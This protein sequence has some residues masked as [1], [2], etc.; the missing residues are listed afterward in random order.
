M[1]LKVRNLERVGPLILLC[2]LCHSAWAQLSV[3]S[4]VQANGTVNVRQTPA[5]TPPLGTQSA[6]ALGSI[7]EGPESAFLNGTSYTWWKVNFDSGIDGWVASIGL[8]LV[9]SGTVD[10]QPLDVTRNPNSVAPGA[11]L[12]VSWKIRNNGTATAP[13]SR[14][15]VRIT[16]S[17]SSWGNG[18]NNVGS[19]LATST[20]SAGATIDQSTT[21]TAPSTPGTYYLWVVADNF[22]DLNQS[23]VNND[24]A[25]SSAF[26]VITPEQYAD[27]VP[28]N[29]GVSPSSGLA[30]TGVQVSFSVR[31]NGPGTSLATT[32]NIRLSTSSAA[33]SAGDPLLGTLNI[34]ALSSGAQQSLSLTYTIPAGTTA[35]QRHIWVIVEP[36]GAPN[37]NQGPNIGNDRVS[38]AFTVTSVQPTLSVTPAN[39]PT[40]PATAGTVSLSVNNTGDGTMSYSASV[41]PASSWLRINSGASGGNSGTIVVAYDANSGASRSSTIQVTANGASGSPALITLTQSG[42]TLPPGGLGF[43]YPIGNRGYAGGVAVPIPEFPTGIVQSSGGG[44]EIVNALFAGSGVANPV[45]QNNGSSASWWISQDVGTFN[46]GYG[47]HAA[48]DWNRGS[49]I[50]DVGE[51]VYAVAAGTVVE[52]RGGTAQSFWTIVL[53][54]DLG[55]GYTAYSIYGHVCPAS[56]SGSANINGTLGLKADFG[57]SVGGQV[58]RGDSIARIGALSTGP[59][60]HFEIRVNT[61]DPSPKPYF[62]AAGETQ[63]SGQ[64]SMTAEEV[65]SAYE[66]MRAAGFVDPSDFIDAHRPGPQEPQSYSISLIASPSAG[67]TVGGGGTYPAGSSRTVT[68]TASSGYTFANWTEGGSVVSQLTSYPF[69]L[70]SNRALVA[71][72]TASPPQ[73]ADLVPQNLGVSPSNGLAGTGVQVSFSVRNNGPGTSLATTANIRLSTSSAAPSAGDPLLGTVNIGGLSSGAQQSLSPSYTIP[74]GTTAGQRHIWVIV[75]PTG[76]PNANQGPNI[77]NDRVSVA[78]IVTSLQPTTYSIAPN[79]AAVDEGAGTLVFTIIRGGDSL[80]AETI[81]ASTVNGAANGYAANNGDYA[82]DVSNLPLNF[83]VGESIRT[84]AVSILND[85]I[86]ESAETFGFIVQRNASD[87]VATHL[88]KSTFTINDNDSPGNETDYP[89]A[90]WIAAGPGHFT[91]ATRAMGDVT[92]IVIH[93]T[94]DASYGAAITWFQDP[95][96]DTSAHYVVRRDGSVVQMVREKDIAHHAGTPGIAA[97][98]VWNERSIGIEVE[99]LANAT[100][101][102]DS[103][104]YQAVKHLVNSI[105]TRYDIPL[106]FPLATPVGSPTKLVAGIV[107]HGKAVQNGVDPVKWEWIYFQSLFEV[108]ADEIS[109]LLTINSPATG[110][111]VAVSSVVVSGTA[112]DSGRGDSGVTSVT[113]N[114]IRAGGD[115]AAGAE[116]ANWSRTVGLITGANTITVVAT[117]GA[118]N[119]TSS[120]RSVAYD[121]IVNPPTRVIALSGNL[122]F[123]EVA[124]GS[125]AQR[126]LTINNAGDSPLTVTGISYPTGF[127]GNWSGTVAAGNAQSI[128]IM[129]APTAAS[130]YGGDL[131]VHA[132]Q[133]SGTPTRVVTGVGT[134]GPILSGSVVAWGRNEQGQTTGIPSAE[135]PY[136]AIGNPPV[137]NGVA[138][139]GVKGIAVGE[140][141][142]VALKNDGTVVAWGVNDYG[143]LDIPADLN[144]VTAISTDGV[145]TIALKHDGTVVGWGRNDYGQSTAPVGLIG[146]KAIAAGVTHTLALKQDGTVVAWGN[147]AAG[148]INVPPGLSGVEAIAAG[149]YHSVA[150]KRD[151]RVIAWG[152]NDYGQASVPSDLIGIKAI[153]AGESHT[154]ALK[155]D[156]TV[157]SWG[158]NDQGQRDIPSGLGGVTAISAGARNTVVLKDDGTVAAWGA[159][160]TATGPELEFGQSIV[161]SGLNRVR[162]IAAGAF[163]AAALIADQ[164]D[165][166]LTQVAMSNGVFRYTLNGITGSKLVIEK[167]SDLSNWSPLSTNT[168]PAAG[169]ILIGD[170]WESGNSGRYYRAVPPNLPPAAPIVIATGLDN[171]SSMVPHGDYLYFADPVRTEGTLKR[172]LKTGGTVS[173]LATGLT[174]SDGYETRFV[175]NSGT[176]YGGYGG[177]NSHRIFSMSASGGSTLTLASVTGGYLFGVAGTEVYFGSGFGNLNRISTSG[178]VPSILAANNWVRSVA[179][180]DGAIYFVE[181]SSRDVRKCSLPSGTVTSL[182]TGN[183]SEGS[184]FIDGVNVYFNLGG[185]IQAVPKAGGIVTPVVSGGGAIGYASDGVRLFFVENNSIRSIQVSGGSAS[186]L[187]NIPTG[188]FTSLVVDD[189][190]I[191]WGDNSGG[192]GMG[193]IWRMA[194]P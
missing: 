49:G 77:G 30:G 145:N 50:D 107:G 151:G 181:Y 31:N 1:N 2:L 137:V 44:T 61:S 5:G 184:I 153:T 159:G 108:I 58:S 64:L 143:Q 187:V 91:P 86:P 193:K 32:A 132:D 51:V 78:F 109:P 66:H 170:P 81:Y 116:T 106:A 6:G 37:A 33:P 174:T 179:V 16:T 190:F 141:H 123:G 175:V 169:W 65:A 55:D 163:H 117:D 26:T 131:T 82:T 79:P 157:V 129:F 11:S 119:Q 102:I 15:Q 191:Y 177:Y 166:Q 20:I 192:V 99:R 126:T 67:G 3:A 92:A 100:E 122:A 149:Y 125:T 138:L 110:A 93:T 176:V 59:H 73:Y 135:P 70:N 90:S 172:V 161:P 136:S 147:N 150:L 173:T 43:D 167:S 17:N 105:R 185:N 180:D 121:L 103:A 80:P 42:S 112:T 165:K 113:V 115:V 88:A 13:T 183:A 74:A 162:A 62:S 45:R 8:D 47:V 124:V 127:S 133:T 87:P 25:V 14:T 156:G 104:Q 68:A 22:S 178:G 120:S 72:F 12:S 39:P 189:S 71:N 128:T 38:V 101:V 155:N 27:L 158:H 41:T 114:G 142:T 182:I 188:S 85:A 96:G 29:L 10:V 146:V 63:K 23:N 60:L 40:Q 9:S 53:Q 111:T 35:G 95:S 130:T 97:S 48:E 24:Y 139:N 52:I 84:V 4:R 36:T 75:E 118:G 76:A 57:L 144:G 89:E 54:H 34:A 69:T 94:E 28:Q 152:R 171:I 18:N 56:I 160:S 98:W 186:T 168:I 46:E 148:Q 140:R 154:V 19:P 83:A 194:K 21:V 7:T 164:P 134:G